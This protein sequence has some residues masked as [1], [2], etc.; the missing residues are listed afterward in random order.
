MSVCPPDATFPTSF[1]WG[2]AAA[3]YQI[4]GGVHEDGKGL[5]VWD[6][7]CRK[8]GAVWHGHSGDVACDHYHRWRDDVALMQEMGLPAYR[9][10]ISWPRVMPQGTGAV[11]PQG[12][13]FYDRLIDAL[14][15]ANVTPYVTLF[16][17]DY[18][19]ELYCQ[20]GW[21]N[22]AS[23][24]WFADYATVVVNAL[25][26]R[27]H[28]WLTLNEPQ[29]FV[30]LGHSLGLHAP[31]DRL[32][33]AQV[34][35][36]MVHVL[37]AHGQAVQAIRA[38]ARGPSAVGY[39]ASPKLC[40]PASLDPADVEAARQST[41][42]CGTPR[43]SGDL[44]QGTWYED[45]VF[46]KQPPAGLVDFDEAGGPVIRPDVLIRH[47]L[48]LIGQPL[49]FFAFN[50]Y[51]APSVRAGS[52]GRPER[53]PY[54]A[55]HPMNALHWPLT[56]DALYWGALF[57][58]ERYHLPI[59]ITENG[60]AN[61]DWIA[62]DGRVHDPQRIDYTARCLLGLR[63]A[64]GEGVDVRGYFHWSLM[65]NFEWAEGYKQRFGLLYV[66][67]PTQQR[68]L[69]DSAYWY[70]DVIASNGGVLDA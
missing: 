67:Y 11:N 10:S 6:V 14:L 13:A 62:R 61:L 45:L 64:I 37:L 68:T 40:L 35:R 26:D 16:H 54:P 66:D 5:S 48:D 59:F 34:L 18:P 2:A 38:A 19:Y 28:H 30:N 36:V 12:L 24:A 21:L 25:S 27:V 52:D 57:L 32:D 17:W 31:G 41:F 29:V 42:N 33:S 7:F 50:L 15:A 53:V 43:F 23:P 51:T 58:W 60:L 46:L 47:D 44:G 3:S 70:R 22:S 39:A 56:P 69:K 9:L 20:G 4:E 49:D 8:P 1:V 65:D 63:R 55:G